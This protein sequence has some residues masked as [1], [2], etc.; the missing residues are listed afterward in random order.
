MVAVL[1]L[2]TVYAVQVVA[3]PVAELPDMSILISIFLSMVIIVYGCD[4]YFWM[5][6]KIV[7]GQNGM[8]RILSSGLIQISVRIING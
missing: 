2:C 7:F 5:V 4:T 8:T 3:A 6:I 1:K